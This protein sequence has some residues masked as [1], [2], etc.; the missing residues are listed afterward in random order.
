MRHALSNS[1]SGF[2]RRMLGAAVV[3]G[4]L[5]ITAQADVWSVVNLH[6]AGATESQAYGV[7]GGQQVGYAVVGGVGRASLWT[8]SAAS[9]VDLN[10]AGATYSYAYGVYGG[11]QGRV[12]M[13]D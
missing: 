7:G 6:P 3:V 9:W 13:L 5:T 8:G 2:A 12:L 1:G 11:Q 4:A 10:P